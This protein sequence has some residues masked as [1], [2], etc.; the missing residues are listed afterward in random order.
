VL[1]LV[2]AFTMTAKF[3]SVYALAAPTV[4]FLALFTTQY[5]MFRKQVVEKIRARESAQTVCP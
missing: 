3:W 2:V 5:L 1:N 4:S